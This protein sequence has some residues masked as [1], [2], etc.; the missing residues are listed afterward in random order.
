[1]SITSATRAELETTDERFIAALPAEVDRGTGPRARRPKG[2]PRTP[3]S[4]TAI[5]SPPDGAPLDLPTPPPRPLLLPPR[6]PG[7]SDRRVPACPAGPASCEAAPSR[8]R[9][10]AWPG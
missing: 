6:V 1:M 4:H 5:L 9:R 7:R 3:P 10:C 8:C 2:T